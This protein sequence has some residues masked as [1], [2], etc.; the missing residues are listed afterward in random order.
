[1]HGNHL[2][3]V[4]LPPTAFDGLGVCVDLPGGLDRGGACGQEAL[5]GQRADRRSELVAGLSNLLLAGQV[6]GPAGGS[7]SP[8]TPPSPT[9]PPRRTSMTKRIWSRCRMRIPRQ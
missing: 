6:A 1:L 5:I 3:L 9:T 2:R 4:I 8:L 7:P